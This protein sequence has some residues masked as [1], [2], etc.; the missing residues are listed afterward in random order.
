MIRPL[1]TEFALFLVPFVLYAAY[2]W[3]TRSGVLDAA[4][5]PA[6]RLALL[7][8]ASLSL[9]AAFLVLL[10]QF[11]G[12]PARSTYVPAHFDGGKFEPGATK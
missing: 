2:L 6:R 9:M 7:L 11:G 10:A 8:V 12:A 3:A 1:F 5:W 4:A